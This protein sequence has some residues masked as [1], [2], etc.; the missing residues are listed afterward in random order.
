M[1]T[2]EQIDA[3]YKAQSAHSH[4]QAMDAVYQAGAADARAAD[5]AATASKPAPAAKAATPDMPPYGT[6]TN[7]SQPKK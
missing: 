4:A 3:L 7:T 2:P 1:K 6:Q 5:K